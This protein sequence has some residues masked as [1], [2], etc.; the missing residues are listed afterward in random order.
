MR[1]LLV[2]FAMLIFFVRCT[3]VQKVP[4]PD[5]LIAPST[6]EDILYDMT[7]VNAARG[8]S[9]QQ[10]S[11]TGVDPACYVFEKY[12]IDSAQ[13]AQSTFYYATSLPEYKELIER[14]R[15]RVERE[16]KVLDSAYKEEKRIKDSIRSARGKVLR[17]K[18]DSLNQSQRDS[19]TKLQ[20]PR[21]IPSKTVIEVNP[22][23]Q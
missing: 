20:N 14:V 7:I 17:N 21:G 22:P 12:A 16:H 19:I 11:Q 1:I 15:V 10:F 9:I 4:R 13:Y 2:I 6:M 5:N 23:L 18:R 8:Y 3:D